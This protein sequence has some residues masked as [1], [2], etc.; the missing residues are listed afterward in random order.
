[1]NFENKILN[2]KKNQILLN[3]LKDVGVYPNFVIQGPTGRLYNS[4]N[5]FF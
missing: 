5:Y 3:K 1:M 4:S 2:I